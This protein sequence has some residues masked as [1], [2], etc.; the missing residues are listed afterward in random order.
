MLITGEKKKKCL[1]KIFKR[2]TTI[3]CS[4]MP[5]A[6]RNTTRRN[7]TSKLHW[8]CQDGWQYFPPNVKFRSAPVWVYSRVYMCCQQIYMY[9]FPLF[10]HTHRHAQKTIPRLFFKIRNKNIY[11]FN[12]IYSR[13]FNF[14]NKKDLREK[15]RK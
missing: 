1:S 3:K 12:P 6:K 13:Y 10:Q 4:S 14:C 15:S 2:L 5:I 7:G 11:I 8:K 9:M